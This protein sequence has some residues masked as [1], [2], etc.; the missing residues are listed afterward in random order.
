MSINLKIF[1]IIILLV[2]LFLIIEKL[3]KKNLSIR[4]ACFWI[5]L[6][7]CMSFIVI[8]P[9]FIFKLSELAGFE[10]SSNMVFIL[11]F[12]FLFYLSFIITANISVQ[13]E[14]IKKLIQEISLLKERV[15][16]IG[17]KD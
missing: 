5:T 10:K 6:I 12:F 4:F 16:E 15:D 7:L 13:N 8:F 1:L 11:G 3:Y 17:K 14:K 9:N 2:L